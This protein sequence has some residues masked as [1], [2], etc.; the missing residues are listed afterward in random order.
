MIMVGQRIFTMPLIFKMVTQPIVQTIYYSFMLT[1][2]KMHYRL[3]ND[4]V[5]L[6]L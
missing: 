4:K 2:L 6:L 5:I 3:G 1:F